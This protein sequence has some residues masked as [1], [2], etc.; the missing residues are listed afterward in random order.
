MVESAM[1]KCRR[2]SLWQRMLLGE[3][4][5]GVR[6]RHR[7]EHDD[8]RDVCR[9]VCL[10]SQSC[11][12]TESRALENLYLSVVFTQHITRLSFSEFQELLTVVTCVKLSD[13]DPQ[14]KLLEN[15]SLQWYQSLIKVLRTKYNEHHRYYS[16]HENII[17]Y[18]VSYPRMLTDVS[19]TVQQLCLRATFVTENQKGMC[20]MVG[21]QSG[22]PVENKW[23]EASGAQ[24]AMSPRHLYES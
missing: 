18:V 13:I 21:E 5:E 16:N 15:L 19:D 7:T 3:A 24:S 2:D 10:T 22:I 8:H 23:L 12:S 9:D 4:E 17:Q 1:E 14:L 11:H 20:I 6:R